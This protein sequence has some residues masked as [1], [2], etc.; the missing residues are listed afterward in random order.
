V[1]IPSVT[2]ATDYYGAA[3]VMLA[4]IAQQEGPAAARTM[5]PQVMAAL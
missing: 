1:T 5:A 2:R 3:L 4:R